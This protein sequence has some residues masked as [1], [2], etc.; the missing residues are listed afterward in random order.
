MAEHQDWTERSLTRRDALY[1]GGGLGLSLALA[2]SALA[3]G[4]RGAP[5]L[6]RGGPLRVGVPND[7]GGWDFDYAAFNLVGI[8]VLKNIYPFTID[9]G[10]RRI[11][12]SRV[13]NTESFV[14]VFAESWTPSRNGRV[15]TL[16]LRRNARFPSGKPVTAE[17]IKWSKDRAFAAKANVAGVYRLIGLTE[18]DQVDIVDDR[19][20]RF[21]HAFASPM[22]TQIHIFCDFFVEAAETKKHATGSDPWAKDWL[23]KN[24]PNGGQYNVT[25]YRAGQEI[26]LQANPRLPIAKPRVKEVRLGVVSSGASMRAQLERGDIDLALGLSRRDVR[27][28]KG[29]SGVRVISVPSNEFTTLPINTTMEPFDKVLVR[30]ALAYAVPY[31]RI[32]SSI[33]RGDARRSTSFAPLDMPGRIN[34][35]P[36]RYDLARAKRL[37]QQAG[38]GSFDTELVIEANNVEQ[39]QIAILVRS[40]FQKIGVNVA[41]KQL[42]PATLGDRRAK[43]NIPL[44]IASGQMWVNDIEY[45]LSVTLTKTAF[46]N[47]SNYSNPTI[48]SIF[49]RL[50]T[51]A[52]KK[53][54]NQLFGR[55]QR[56][57]AADVPMLML[58]QPNFNLPLRSGIS[59]WVQPVDG[60][61][62][63]YYLQ[64]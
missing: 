48:E 10:V 35:Y 29:K 6:A 42:D 43:K 23:S 52:N 51:T 39:Q 53:T 46:L 61:A 62:R 31:D 47:Y 60:L 5:D 56:I 45:L 33:F 4:R 18:P 13:G 19:T 64:A 58:G 28:L 20:V 40:E 24:P 16:K 30:R 8:M 7:V 57:L 25:S 44:Q 32:L 11:G 55:V 2:P 9:Y 37:M 36:Y 1:L 50:H 49:T 15:W 38:Q 22:A 26:V 63:F 21:T 17:D 41:I 59:G 27:E 3:R 34:A 14:P 54:R 12:S